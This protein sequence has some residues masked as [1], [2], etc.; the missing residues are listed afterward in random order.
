MKKKDVQIG[1]TYWIKISG[2]VVP[3]CIDYEVPNGGWT[4]TNLKTKRQI[5]I[6]T[7][8]RLRGICSQNTKEL[9]L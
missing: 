8:A 4:G 7:A 9:Y 1:Q 2:D 6:K 5:R 3:V